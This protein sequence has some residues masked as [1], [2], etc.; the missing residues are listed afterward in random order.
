MQT[1][2]KDTNWVIYHILEE[3]EDLGYVTG[4]ELFAYMQDHPDYRRLTE[5]SPDD[6]RNKVLPTALTELAREG[7]V[8]YESS[9]NGNLVRIRRGCDDGMQ[10]LVMEN[11]SRPRNPFGLFSD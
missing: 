3:L 8:E 2:S 5:I 9:N 6:L 7:L 10:L 1:L 11:R 4:A